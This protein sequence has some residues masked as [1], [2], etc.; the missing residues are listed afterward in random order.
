MGP[1]HVN[2]AEWV[3]GTESHEVWRTQLVKRNRRST[4]A[5][6]PGENA[7]VLTMSPETIMTGSQPP[8]VILSMLFFVAWGHTHCLC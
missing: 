8:L 1:G 4:Q 7:K 5:Q 6:G 3:R 2:V